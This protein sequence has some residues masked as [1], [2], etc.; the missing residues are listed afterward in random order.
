[1]MEKSVCFF[2]SVDTG[3]VKVVTTRRATFIVEKKDIEDYY[4]ASVRFRRFAIPQEQWFDFDTEIERD[5]FYIII[6]K[7]F[8]DD[9]Y[10][11]VF[12]EN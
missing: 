1:M 4:V 3:W 5:D 12:P 9:L 6:D 10:Y 11:N 8:C 2:R 7:M